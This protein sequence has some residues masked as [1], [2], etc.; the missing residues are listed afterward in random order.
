MKQRM[1][2]K[3]PAWSVWLLGGAVGITLTVTLYRGV[4]GP[5]EAQKAE[6]T[7]VNQ[8]VSE[9]REENRQLEMRLKV[10]EQVM[11]DHRTELESLHIDLGDR[12]QLNRRIAA[13]I[14]LAKEQSL[15]VM[16][17]QPGK[18]T[19][20]EHYTLVSLQLDARAGFADHLNYLEQLHTSFPDMSVMGLELNSRS[21]D[22]NARPTGTYSLVWFTAKSGGASALGSQADATNRR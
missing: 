16:Q 10:I 9:Q 8:A 5:M 14:A 3:M 1:I 17:L 15:E 2:D 22:G 4:I 20:A 18:E 6:A 19:D 11:N 21:R 7:Q 12:S 13:L